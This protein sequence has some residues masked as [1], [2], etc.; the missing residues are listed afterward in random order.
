MGLGA[1]FLGQNLGNVECGDLGD[2]LLKEAKCQGE[3][4]KVL[5]LLSQ[6]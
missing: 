2:S 6:S 3:V 1:Q 4:S 5:M